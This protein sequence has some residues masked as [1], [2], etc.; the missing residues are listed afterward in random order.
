ME[1]GFANT[2]LIGRWS[3]MFIRNNLYSKKIDKL[4][5][6]KEYIYIY[7]VCIMLVLHGGMGR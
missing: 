7:F 3:D 4:R 1:L 2:F 5:I 6:E